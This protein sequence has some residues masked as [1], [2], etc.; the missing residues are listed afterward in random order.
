MASLFQ[1]RKP[2]RC[3]LLHPLFAH[4]ATIYAVD[5]PAFLVFWYFS[6]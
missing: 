6:I 1:A 2:S 3:I 5:P 4:H